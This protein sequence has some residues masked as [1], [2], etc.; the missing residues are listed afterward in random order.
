MNGGIIDEATRQP[1]YLARVRIDQA[2][3]PRDIASK[4][5][6]GMPADV[7]IS[8]G[9]RT[10]LQYLLAPLTDRLAKSMRES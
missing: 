1:H 2:S 5:T 9:G 4:L 7:L 10:M 3:I 8:T 6:P